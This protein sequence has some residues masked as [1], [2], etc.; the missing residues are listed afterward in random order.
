LAVAA[1]GL[2]LM[3]QRILT[4]WASTARIRNAG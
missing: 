1:D 4:P 2:L 3:V